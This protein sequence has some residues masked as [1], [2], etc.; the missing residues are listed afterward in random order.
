MTCIL[1]Q[2]ERSVGLNDPLSVAGNHDGLVLGDLAEHVEQLP[3]LGIECWS[4][5]VEIVKGKRVTSDKREGGDSSIHPVAQTLVV[6]VPLTGATNTP[7]AQGDQSAMVPLTEATRHLL[8]EGVT[9]YLHEIG[10][11]RIQPPKY[12]STPLDS[13][14]LKALQA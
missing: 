13:M 12:K 6:L 1:D 10:T 2:A 8:R 3:N 11:L 5:D 7:L 4:V 9:M 14:S